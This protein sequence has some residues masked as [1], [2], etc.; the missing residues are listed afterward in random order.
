M[1]GERYTQTFAVT[2]A[3]CDLRRRM[4][5]GALLRLCQNIATDHC[6]ALGLTSA[7]YAQSHTAFLLAKL[8]CRW[9]RPILLDERI[10]LCTR[11]EVAKHAVYKRITEVR[12]EDGSLAAL[13]D[14]RWVLI[15]TESRRIL[16]RP[17]EAIA[18]LPFA[19]TVVEALP[20]ALPRPETAEPVC[21]CRAAYSQCDQNGHINNTRYIDLAC[22]LLPL[23]Q[24]AEAPLR[25]LC[26]NYHNE[27]PAGQAFLAERARLDERTW[28]IA[29]TQPD[30][31]CFEG[32]F[33]LAEPGWSGAGGTQG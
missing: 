30:R 18:A 3:D 10:T 11:P 19:Q 6:T 20:F 26:V 5:P 1:D 21:E 31:R 4:T 28:Y 7:Y 33:T 23:E 8:A 24:L 13:A 25:S 17:T 16:R 9:E 27:I 12:G 2:S 22:D 29:C 14:S 32:V 15:D